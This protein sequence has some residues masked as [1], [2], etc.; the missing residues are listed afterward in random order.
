MDIWHKCT[1]CRGHV[2]D[3]D[4]T[5][6]IISYSIYFIY[7]QQMPFPPGQ[8]TTLFPLRSHYKTTYNP[9]ARL[10][11]SCMASVSSPVS[12]D[13]AGMGDAAQ[14]TKVPHGGWMEH[15]PM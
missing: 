12:V 5:N 10:A 1:S 14:A 6:V 15:R 11:A 8:P 4:E 3:I 9:T 2:F 7:H 13:L